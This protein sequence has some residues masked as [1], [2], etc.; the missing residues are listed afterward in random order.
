MGNLF[1]QKRKNIYL[2]LDKRPEKLKRKKTFFW[3]KIF[4]V[5]FSYFQGVYYWNIE[6][7]VLFD[8][9]CFD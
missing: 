5:F 1:M 8:N 6:F 7:F 9:F 4:N 2:K 3:G